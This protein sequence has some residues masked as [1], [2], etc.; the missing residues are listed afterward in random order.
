M[1][2]LKTI[3]EKCGV[4]TAT[5]SKALNDQ[6]DVS[7]ETKHRIK[8]TAEALGYFPNAAARALKTNRSYNIG[9]L[10]EEEA[11]S[12]LT[13]EYFSG[14]LNGLKVQAEKQGYDIT[15]I[16]TCFENRKMSYYEHCRY[17]NFEGI[18]IVCADFASQGVLE[19]M[20]S[21]F[22]VVTIDYTHYNCTAVCSNNVKGMEE[23][24]KYIYKK[25]HRKIA[26]IHGQKN[27][28][29]TRERLTSFYRTMEELHIKVN[30]DY[31]REAAYLETKGAAEQTEILLDMD[32]PPTCI[33]YPDDTSL[34]GGKNVIMERGMHIPEDVSIAGYDGTRISQLSHPR[35]TTIRQDTEEIGREAARRLIDAIEKP[36]TT[37]I[38]RVVIEGT[39][40]TGQ[41][42]GEL[43]ET[44]SEE[45]EK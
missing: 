13:H 29:V 35:I 34:I 10:F 31:I 22:P 42:V 5:V 16:N 7:E 28:N 30:E 21:A 44:T 6:K 4:S 33:L 39:L 18:V 15:F 41:S 45:D 1:V 32:D 25:G 40:I 12:G 36:R 27:S 11:G 19:L 9:V 43:P 24:L 38:E 26:Y 17:R 3:A 8:K 2:S 23:L 14:V 37:L 20:N